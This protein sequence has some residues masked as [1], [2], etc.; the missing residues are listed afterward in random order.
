LPLA[1]ALALLGLLLFPAPKAA[2]VAAESPA[3]FQAEPA[4]ITVIL[5][6]FTR[7]RTR[8]ALSALVSGRLVEVR[9]E[10]GDSVAADGIFARLD[11]VLADL[12]RAAIL[13]KQEQ[14]KSKIAYLEKEVNRYQVLYDRNSMA[15][16]RLDALKEDLSQA[17]L[18]LRELR[19][20]EL[21]AAEILSR[22]NIFAPPGWRIIS[23]RSEPEEW[24]GAGTTLGEVGDYHSLLVPFAL[25]PEEYRYLRE[26]SGKMELR[27]PDWQLRMPA[28]L[29]RV[30][31][32]FDEVTRKINIELEISGKLPEQRGGIRAEL[33]L[34]LP[35]PSGAL[36]VPASAVRN[37][38][39]SSWLTTAAGDRVMVI[40]LGPGNKAETVRVSGRDLGPGRLFLLNPPSASG[41]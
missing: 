41:N 18:G 9:G 26:T 35:D 21:K 5:V 24:V 11:P 37:R 15:E 25:G 10:M 1:L 22:H 16:A 29:A 30:S 17:R 34:E 14:L 23:R 8:V 4:T 28:T 36:Q 6:G 13:V 2:A 33:A 38:Y 12:D 3:T 31:P 32:E 40:V 19:T 7:A 20:E 39:E 27:L